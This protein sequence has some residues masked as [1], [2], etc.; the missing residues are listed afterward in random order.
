MSRRRNICQGIGAR[1]G[2]RA[3]QDSICEESGP[4]SVFTAASA[5]DVLSLARLVYC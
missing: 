2:A 3:T 4:V 1:T 5:N